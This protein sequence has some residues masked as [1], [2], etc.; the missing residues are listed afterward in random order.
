MP[1]ISSVGVFNL[2]AVSCVTGFPSGCL[3]PDT[4]PSFETVALEGTWVIVD[5][6]QDGVRNEG[7]IGGSF[8]IGGGRFAVE[9]RDGRCFS[10]PCVNDPQANPQT[11]D[12]RIPGEESE[13]LQLGIYRVREG[14]LNLVMAHPGKS[15]PSSFEVGGSESRFVYGLERVE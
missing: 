2:V 14:V 11:I 4:S 1:R 10:L 15:R 6:T 3:T 12:L 9:A 5:A 8:V 13:R 7:M